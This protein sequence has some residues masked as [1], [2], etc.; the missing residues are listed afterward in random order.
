MRASQRTASTHRLNRVAEACLFA[1]LLGAP[2]VARAQA[3]PAVAA[4]AAD[5]GQLDVVTITAEKRLTLLDKTPTAITVLRGSKLAEEGVTQLADV[6]GL[7]PD[8]SFTTGQ[9]AS[10][11]F[12]RGIGNV[13][14]LAGGDP[15][16]AMYADGSYVSDQ[17]S[18]NV[19]LFDVQRIEVLRGPQGALY[20]RNATG[21]A[22]NILSERPTAEFKARVAALVGEYGRRESEG[23]VSGP[24]GA[25]STRL[26]LSYQVKGLDGTTRNPLA[27]TT[28]GPV[29]AGGP[30]T[31]APDKLD[32]LSSR[33]LRLQSSTDFGNDG[34]LRLIVGH[35]HENDAGPSMPVLVDPAMIPILLFGVQPSTEPRVVKSQGA[36]NRIEVNTLQALYEQ[37][38]GNATLSVT[39][40]W[41]HSGVFRAWDSDTTESLTATS[42][43]AT[44][45]R[46]SSI[47]VHLASDDAGAKSALQWLVGATA[48]RFDQQQDIDI[49][50]QVPLGFLVP[51]QPLDVPFPGGVEFA[52]GG[53]V[54]ATSEAVYTDLRYQL[55]PEWAL[56]AGLRY[57]RDHKA[58]SEY[59]NVAAFGINGTGAPSASWAST[60]GSLGVEYK[61]SRATM[62]YAKVSHGFKSGAVNLGALQPE[63]VRPEKVTAFELGLKTEFWDRR[64]ILSAAAFTSKYRDMQVS[65][66]GIANTI[67]ANAASSKISGIEIESSLRPIPALT[68]TAGL[69]LMD[70]KY[71]DFTNTDLRNNPTQPVNVRGKQLAEVSKAQASLA[72]DLNQ[73]VGGY[74]ATF[75]ADVVWRGK[76]YFTEFNTPDAVQGAYA[77]LNLAASIAPANG[78]WKVYA[79]LRNATDTTAQ[80]SM[81]IAS[82]VLGGARQ[83]TYTPPREFGIGATVEF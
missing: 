51:G 32:D 55:T 67:L 57:N 80:T 60:P 21:G 78:R 81:S 9:G 74:K 44:S 66:V 58:A 36:T 11:L 7:S 63:L 45:S 72:A 22:I 31:T 40:S 69:G 27:G 53:S 73:A 68:L 59:Q 42:S 18:S 15:G 82:P 83:V 39:A 75:H 19:S 61:V 43:F 38:L 12:I 25:G 30:T 46:D 3:A 54:K 37:P 41:R 23:F 79:R 13:F 17:T 64:G 52:L 65:Q 49:S 16:V 71:E 50:T 24:V 20:G 70:P 5:S 62:A 28:S 47:D 35:Y 34:N 6:V 76:Y 14:I 4:S 10:Q 26:R 77:M 8:T 1:F 48:L 56:L 2:L 33:A 29:I